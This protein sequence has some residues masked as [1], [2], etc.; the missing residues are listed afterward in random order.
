MDLSLHGLNDETHLVVECKAKNLNAGLLQCVGYLIKKE[1]EKR[2]NYLFVEFSNFAGYSPI[3][4][5]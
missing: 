4:F 5:C 2:V 3:R 1:E